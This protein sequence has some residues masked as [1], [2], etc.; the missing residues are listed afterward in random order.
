MPDIHPDHEAVRSELSKPE[1][2]LPNPAHPELKQ[3]PPP[4]IH[5]LKRIGLWVG[6]GIV[7]I[8]LVFAVG[9]MRFSWQNDALLWLAKYIPFP[10]AV[11]GGDWLS[12]HEYQTDV[13]NIS[14]F[15]ERNAAPDAADKLGLSQDV[16]TRR[17][18]LNKMVGESVLNTIAEEK[19]I[20]VTQADIDA[21]YDSYVEQSGNATEVEKYIQQLYGWDVAQFKAKLIKPQVVQ[22]KIAAGFYADA[23]KETQGIRDGVAKDA[24]T[25]G[26]VAKAKSDDASA[27]K[28]GLLDALNTKQ[29]EEAYGDAATALKALKAGQVSEVLE[30]TRGYEIVQV[31]KT[32]AAAKKADGTM[33]TLRRILKAPNFNTW[34]QDTVN[35]KVKESRVMLFEP[36]FR[37]EAEC[38][39]QAKTEPACD[40]EADANTNTQE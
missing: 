19:N 9:Y 20:T 12:Y 11:V 29:L 4:H 21:T 28:S 3:L 18:I 34:L 22:D 35:T 13:P 2:E 38:G 23:K 26:D 8:V 32:E 40:P 24:K 37:W 6:A 27:A 1:H 16:Y 36:R 15:L 17:I 25:F 33:Y 39:V 31:E 14:S 7:A 5:W 30:T 10:V